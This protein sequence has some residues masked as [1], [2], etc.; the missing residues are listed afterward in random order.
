MALK[1]L[2]EF[3]KFDAVSFFKGKQLLLMRETPWKDY[4]S[5]KEVGA[6]LKVIIWS[7]DTKYT[8]EGVSNEGS[9]MDIKISGLRA[10]DID[11]NNRGFIR[12]SNPTGVVYGEY[13]NEL[14]IKADGFE[15]VK[16]EGGE[17]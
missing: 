5:G 2:R 7:D 16:E 6:K 9:E 4:D 11:R 17:K 1:S 14:S 12:L 13:Q 10:E 8:K 3:L 15:F